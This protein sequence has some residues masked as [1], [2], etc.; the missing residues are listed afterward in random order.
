MVVLLAFVLCK[1]PVA[2]RETTVECEVQEMV[3]KEDI[4]KETKPTDK[5]NTMFVVDKG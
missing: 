1:I 2:F 4:V 5:V 3:K